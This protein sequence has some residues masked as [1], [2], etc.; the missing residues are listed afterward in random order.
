MIGSY[1]GAIGAAEYKRIQNK[2]SAE[3]SRYECIVQGV[4]SSSID[5]VV[6]E[7]VAKARD[8]LDRLTRT[9]P[10][11]AAAWATL[12]LVFNAQRNTG[13]ALPPEEATNIHQ[14]LYLADK[15]VEAANRAVEIAPNDAFVH[16]LVAR[17]A[18][19]ACQ[20]DLVRI[21]ALRAIALNPYDSQNL[22]PLGNYMAYVGFWDE[23]VAIA[24]KGIALTA[25][26]TPRWW[27]W[28]VAKGAWLRGDYQLALDTFRQS[29]VEQLW[30]SHLHL[31]YT[32]PLLGRTDEARA[33][34]AVL[35]KMRPAFTV[36]EADAYY[37]TWCF[38]APFREKMQQA[39]R[40]AGLPE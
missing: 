10:G 33:H 20:P 14:R 5:I 40:A 39:L 19:M 23:G 27:R 15:A 28:A 35:L 25:P 1:W 37:K 38:A 24:D 29:Y 2:S 4:I 34:V 30:L 3:L 16:G 6:L 12:V 8:C 9:E 22:G 36:R 26:A 7:P 32:L 17:A 31:A 11:N 13:F 18:W 21:E